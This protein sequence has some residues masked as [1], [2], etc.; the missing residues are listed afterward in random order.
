MSMIAYFARLTR[1]S[2]VTAM[3][4]GEGGRFPFEIGLLRWQVLTD[5][6]A[7]V[8]RAFASS[9]GQV[10]AGRAQTSISR[11]YGGCLGGYVVRVERGWVRA[12]AV[13]E[14]WTASRNVWGG[15]MPRTGG[16]W[17]PMR[18][19]CHSVYSLQ[20][21]R[22]MMREGRHGCWRSE[23]CLRCDP[24]FCKVEQFEHARQRE[25]G[26][27]LPY[28]KRQFSAEKSGRSRCTGRAGGGLGT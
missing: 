10:V 12:V 25:A 21:L 24:N 13:T 14:E 15:P 20:G 2:G 3:E 7:R 22:K 19:V 26:R 18:L 23:G 17:E 6:V 28:R 4:P 5:R 27:Q 9:R 11:G 8:S 1:V 16:V